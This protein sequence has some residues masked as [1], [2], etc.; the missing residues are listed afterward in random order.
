MAGEGYLPDAG[1]ESV[2]G[3]CSE[4]LISRPVTDAA[5]DHADDEPPRVALFLAG[6]A[7]GGAGWGTDCF[8]A[9]F[10]QAMSEDRLGM[11]CGPVVGQHLFEVRVVR[12]QTEEKI[13]DVGPGLDVM[14]F[15]AR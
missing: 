8:G 10:F 9:R 7:M 1:L 14:T 12:I 2:T 5:M 15:G 4:N 3:R 6:A 13:A 11:G